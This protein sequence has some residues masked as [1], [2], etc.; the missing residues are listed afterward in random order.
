MVTQ[1]TLKEIGKSAL[2]LLFFGAVSGAVYHGCIVQRT[3]EDKTVTEIGIYKSYYDAETLYYDERSYI[4]ID[5]KNGCFD[6]EEL[7]EQV[8]VGEHIKLEYKPIFALFP[9]C[10]YE[11]LN[12]RR[13]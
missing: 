9:D 6:V 11:V 4:T 13:N 5:Q 10:R 12:I 1:R 7:K 8:K 2:G 3:I